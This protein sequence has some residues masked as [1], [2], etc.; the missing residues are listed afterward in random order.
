M[1]EKVCLIADLSQAMVNNE[2]TGEKVEKAK[3][4]LFKGNNVSPG[5][6][7]SNAKEINDLGKLQ[8]EL[9]EL[10][11]KFKT[12]EGE[13]HI[14]RSQLKQH[15]DTKQAA[16]L[17][18]IKVIDD[19]H[20]KYNEKITLTEKELETL[21][22]KL[23]F[24]DMEYKTLSERCRQLEYCISKSKQ[25]DTQA[26]QAENAKNIGGFSQMQSQR[27]QTQIGPRNV[28]GKSNEFFKSLEFEVSFR[29]EG[30]YLQKC[31][32]P[33]IFEFVEEP[34]IMHLCSPRTPMSNQDKPKLKFDKR[35]EYNWNDLPKQSNYLKDIYESLS[36]LFGE[37]TFNRRETRRKVE[38]ILDT[39][40]K[41]L[42]HNKEVLMFLDKLHLQS[43][44]YDDSDQALLEN[45]DEVNVLTIK[46]LLSSKKLSED[47]CGVEGRRILGL[48]FAL[49]DTSQIVTDLIKKKPDFVETLKLSATAIGNLRRPL[50]YTGILCGMC[51][52]LR[53]LL[54]EKNLDKS[55]VKTINMTVEEIIF[56]RPKLDVLAE[57][58]NVL[59]AGRNHLEFLSALCRK[60][61]LDS[62]SLY[63][64][65][66]LKQA[67]FFTKSACPL[68]L[69]CMQIMGLAGL[70]A[71]RNIIW[72][73]TESLIKWLNNCISI[74]ENKKLNWLPTNEEDERCFNVTECLLYLLTL[75]LKDYRGRYLRPG[76][77]ERE[78]GVTE[79]V[80]SSTEN[81]LN[82]HISIIGH[83]AILLK[84][85]L[86]TDQRQLHDNSYS[87]RFA[88]LLNSMRISKSER[89]KPVQ[90]DAVSWLTDS[91][92]GDLRIQDCYMRQSTSAISE[93]DVMS[94]LRISDETKI[95]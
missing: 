43:C 84:R 8:S 70:P 69:L 5:L 21:K 10:K 47:E 65:S 42:I 54:L 94:A 88:V 13:V 41:I 35:E 68:K 72:Y 36:S 7:S 9:R 22:T 33:E 49:M 14:L 83:G 57:V 48:V 63:M 60:A 78:D 71:S 6:E 58:V 26:S 17:Q 59:G 81:K 23:Q 51:F 82:C 2:T 24:K 75:C 39:C 76:A 30:K 50:I 27:C 12:K 87:L 4:Q 37:V 16:A 80:E 85:I 90:K 79:Q 62:C 31:L 95:Y 46:S 40:E 1:L 66:K 29:H 11:D 61:S 20:K 32:C 92:E 28:G 52:V 93:V 3:V 86:K 19:I 38:A 53:K 44:E 64:D 77:Y 15:E 74:P 73:L 34:S 91:L 25:N 67:M 89:L 45:E 56:T 18:N 55:I